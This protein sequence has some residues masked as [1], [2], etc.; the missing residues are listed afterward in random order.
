M[1]GK[2]ERA[3]KTIPTVYLLSDIIVF[4]ELP[5]KEMFLRFDVSWDMRRAIR[6][7]GWASLIS[8]YLGLLG[9]LSCPAFTSFGKIQGLRQERV[10]GPNL[11]IRDLYTKYFSP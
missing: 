3:V 11:E 8:G 5:L 7:S 2:N 10:Q 1:H 6:V 4:D 9:S